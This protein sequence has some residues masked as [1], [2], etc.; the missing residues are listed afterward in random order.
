MK[1][2]LILFSII[3]LAVVLRFFQLSRVPSS[4][5]WDE[6]SLGY[7]AWNISE[8]LKDEHGVFLPLTNFKAF[9]D[10]KP[11]FYIYAVA[12]SMKIFGG[13]D[14]SIRF[15]SAFFG[16]I[17]ILSAYLITK[18]LLKAK[19]VALLSAFFLAVSPWAINLSR[20]AFEANVAWSL[21]LIALTLFLYKKY[22]FSAFVFVFPLYTFNSSRIFIP[23]FL[24][25]L[26]IFFYK[27]IIKN[28][29][30]F[31]VCCLL[32]VVML[33]P[34]VPHLMSKEGR[35][36][37]EEVNIFTNP[38]P[39]EV[40]NSRIQRDNNVFWSKIINNRRI[41]ILN[42]FLKHFTDNFRLDFLFLTGDKNGTFSDGKT[43]E[44]YLFDLLLISIGIYFL[45]AKEKKGKKF[46]LFLAFWMIAAI[47]PAAVARETPHALRTLN[48]LPVY[49]IFS[50]L[51]LLFFVKYFRKIFF[52]AGC[53]VILFF[54]FFMYI[55]NYY[56]SYQFEK[57]ENFQYGYKE[58]VEYLEKNKKAYS[59]IYVTGFYG[60]PYIYYLWYARVPA[61][62]F[63]K[64]ATFSDNFFGF[65]TVKSAGSVFFGL[66][67]VVLKNNVL[68]VVSPDEKGKFIGKKMVNEINFPDGKPAFYFYEN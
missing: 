46:F 21:F 20:V 18:K 6:V 29:I 36:R 35:L 7:N 12:F 66:Q 41:Y 26:L 22:I 47:F 3:L 31:V 53:V 48:I 24:I 57:T 33:A 23:I 52:V 51:G 60:R 30:R 15:P 28:K 37:F 13:S 32:F 38:V 1:T 27:E 58:M 14:F 59:Q 56:H 2:K 45:L 61:G 42:D 54:S 34:L 5:Y 64:D 50:A 4:L 67:D 8:T 10:Y 63:L 44:L 11:P 43:G 40:S 9:G 17:S 65:Y 16:T 62:K 68:Y 19:K 49:Q 55:K 39:I 25:I